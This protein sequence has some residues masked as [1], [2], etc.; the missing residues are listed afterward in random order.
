MNISPHQNSQLPQRVG[1]S[2]TLKEGPPNEFLRMSQMT[3][4]DTMARVHQASTSSP[5]QLIHKPAKIVTAVRNKD[6]QSAAKKASPRS[7]KHRYK[8]CV[9]RTHSPK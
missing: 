1:T 6:Q 2:G 4:K 8:L 9:A 5:D 7:I 3:E